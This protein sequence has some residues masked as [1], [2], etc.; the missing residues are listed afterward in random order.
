[1]ACPTPRRV[2]Q[3]VM[4]I[5]KQTETL[6]STFRANEKRLRGWLE[7]RLGDSQSAEDVAQSTFLTVWIRAQSTHINNPRALIFKVA[8]DLAYNEF[9]RRS[10]HAVPF[11]SINVDTAEDLQGDT[12]ENLD[13][14]D[15]YAKRQELDFVLREI[16]NLPPKHRQ[17]F[18]LNRFDGRN[19]S[20]IAK[21]MNVSVSSVEKYM[22]KS[23]Q[24]LRAA[25]LSECNDRKPS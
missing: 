8:R 1:M 21:I 5:P 6:D 24:M 10:R 16:Q 25:K 19:Y 14:E 2:S 4:T 11:S 22:M 7:K 17:A 9:K 15:A 12:T 18:E 20:Q 13:S 3:Y 23:L